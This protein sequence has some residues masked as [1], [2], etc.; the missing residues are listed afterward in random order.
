MKEI[1]L[2]QGKIAIVDDQDYLKVLAAGSWHATLRNERWYAE[3]KTRLSNG[4][5]TQGL[6]R[7]IMGLDFGDPRQVDHKD[8]VNTLD[9]RR[10]NLRMTFSQNQQNVG[11]RS[12]NTSGFKGVSWWGRT[13]KCRVSISVHGKTHHLGLFPTPELSAKAYDEA[14]VKLHGEFAVTNAMLGLLKKPVQSVKS[15]MQEVA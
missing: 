10:S 9:N 6:H 5:K 15:M 1:P 14:A 13:Q 3:R 12:H 2:T 4:S 7:F 11:K 8:R